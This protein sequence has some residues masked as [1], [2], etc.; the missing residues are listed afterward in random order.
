MLL[1]A[2]DA[3]LPMEGTW[4]HVPIDDYEKNI[5]AIITHPHIEAHKPKK[6]LLVTPPPL[7]E[8]KSTKLDMAD[9][10]PCSVRQ[11]AVSAAYGQRVR[12]IAARHDNVVLIDLYKALMDEAI[13]KSPDDYSPG[14]P[15]LGTPENGK[16]GYLE[17]LLPDGLHTAGEAYRIFYDI[18]HPHINWAD[19]PWVL[20]DWNDFKPK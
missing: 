2:N 12:D 17:V 7:D 15:L 19:H 18:L 1:G 14:G 6:I 11:A 8:I 13:T 4:Q 16:S 10:F 5:E 3:V 20:P 9:G